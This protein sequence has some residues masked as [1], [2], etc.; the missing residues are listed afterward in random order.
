MKKTIYAVIGILFML[1]LTG[2]GDSAKM[3]V[4]KY[5]DLYT[6]LDSEV[7]K[8]MNNIVTEENL[9]EKQKEKYEAIFK[10]QYS[11]LTY[12]ITSEEYDGDEATI[13]A[14][15]KVYDLYKVQKEA[16][17][18]LANH[19]DEFNDENGEYDVIRY[20]DYKL[21]QMKM[22]TER[23][24]YT[25]DFYVV[26]TSDGWVVSSLSNSDLEKIHGVYNYES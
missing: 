18:Y 7:V 13:K 16:S 3:A 11:D 17:V 10:K 6:S 12:E 2:C 25:I 24:E 23:I 5:L 1:C 22:M 26:K 9:T 14:K 4:E 8:D 21:D 19:E 20:L 15:I